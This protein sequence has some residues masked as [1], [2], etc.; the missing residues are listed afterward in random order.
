MAKHIYRGAG[1]P[2]FIPEDV[3]HHYVDTLT[4]DA[5]LSVGNQ[6][7]DDWV[8][9]A[10]HSASN[11]IVTNTMTGNDTSQSPSVAAIKAY[12]AAQIQNITASQFVVEYLTLDDDQI[13][14]ASVTLQDTP[15]SETDVTLDL[16]GAGAQVL[17]EDYVVT[18]GVISWVGLSLQDN[19]AVGDKLRVTYS[20]NS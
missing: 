3:G 11:G 5:Y 8:I 19:L 12:I 7:V 6:S 2:D 16:I 4:K 17:G 18:G 15:S 1:A 10:G 9:A 14:N 20:R 13:T